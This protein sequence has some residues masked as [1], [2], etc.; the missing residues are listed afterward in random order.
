[1]ADSRWIDSSIGAALDT[2]DEKKKICSSMNRA[3][4]K[5]KLQKEMVPVQIPLAFDSHDDGSNLNKLEI[6]VLSP[7]ETITV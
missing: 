7:T 6:I 4:G 3:A 5:S 1:M 2:V